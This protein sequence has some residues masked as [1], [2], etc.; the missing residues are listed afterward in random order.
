MTNSLS[1][2]VALFGRNITR[3]K[4]PGNNGLLAGLQ[5]LYGH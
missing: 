2:F 5:A 3:P 1:H 4:T